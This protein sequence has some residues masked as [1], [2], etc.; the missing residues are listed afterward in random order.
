MSLLGNGFGNFVFHQQKDADINKYN[1]VTD[2]T[3]KKE[4]CL[5][6]LSLNQSVF[7]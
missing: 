4:H 7:V 5:R 2:M 6:I 3:E 1:F